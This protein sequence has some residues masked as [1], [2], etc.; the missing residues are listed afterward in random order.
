[1]KITYTPT[2][3]E[4]IN[5]YLEIGD[6]TLLSK[7]VTMEHP[8]DSMDLTAFMEEMVIPL[9][10]GVGYHDKSIKRVI[11]INEEFDSDDL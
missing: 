8:M 10:R 3:E 11:T 1:M 7:T 6:P 9:L 4:E 5:Q 2:N